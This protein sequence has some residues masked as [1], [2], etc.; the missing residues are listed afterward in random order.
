M[1]HSRKAI[2][3]FNNDY[4]CCQAVLGALHYELHIDYDTA[5][6]IGAAFGGGIGRQGLTCGAVSAAYMA[7]GLHTGKNICEVNDT[8]AITLNLTKKFNLV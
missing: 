6:N 1:S 3:L 2:E 8:K 7:I 4:N 5:I